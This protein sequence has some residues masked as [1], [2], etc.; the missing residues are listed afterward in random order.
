MTVLYD[1]RCAFCRRSRRIGEALDWLHQFDW[2]PNKEAMGS[3]V[4]MDGDR[5]L[6]YWDAMKAMAL[7]VPITWLL[8]LPAIALLPIFNPIG[9]RVYRWIAANR[10]RLPG[11]TCS[12]E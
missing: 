4:V 5:K 2:Q 3:I 9:E 12:I 6:M 7:R 1:A 8:I 11:D 10:Y